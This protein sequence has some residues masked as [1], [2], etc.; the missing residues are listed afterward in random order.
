M[1]TANESRHLFKGGVLQNMKT[2]HTSCARPFQRSQGCKRP[3]FSQ[4]PINKTEWD[5]EGMDRYVHVQT[6]VLTSKLYKIKD[7]PRFSS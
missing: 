6:D 1:A 3:I 5:N 2:P 4:K 7:V